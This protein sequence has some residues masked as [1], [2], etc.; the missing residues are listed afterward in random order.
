VLEKKPT[1]ISIATHEYPVAAARPMNSVLDAS[2]LHR[3]LG[4]A[5][6]QWQDGVDALLK[7]LS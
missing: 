1:I 4:V 5:P 7:K 6:S 2:K 3:A